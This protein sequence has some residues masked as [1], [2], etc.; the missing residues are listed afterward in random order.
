MAGEFVDEVDEVGVFVLVRAEDVVLQEGLDGLVFGG[1]A[2]AEGVGEGGALQLF[3]FGGHGGGEEV[4]VAFFW[5][6]GEDFVDGWAEV[7]VEE[8]VAFVHDQVFEAAEA[9]PFGVFEVVEEPPRGGH[10]DVRPFSERDGLGDHVHP[11]DD[12]GGFDADAAAEGFEGFG[13][14]EG[15]FARGREDAGEE[16]AGVGPEGLQDGEGEGGGFA[17]A[18]FGERD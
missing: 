18:G 3:D 15:E 10:D 5:D 16:G 2:H 13:D 1:D 7:Q 8:L 17:G 9:E 14:L 12:G 11:A 6:D 4:G